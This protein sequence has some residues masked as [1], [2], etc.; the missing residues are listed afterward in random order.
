M[1]DA[2]TFFPIADSG[3]YRA[4]ARYIYG[5]VAFAD[6]LY[7]KKH[8]VQDC[9]GRALV[10]FGSSPSFFINSSSAR[11]DLNLLQ[12]PVPPSFAGGGQLKA[13]SKMQIRFG[14][15]FG[16]DGSPPPKNPVILLLHFRSKVEIYAKSVCLKVVGLA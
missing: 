16:R 4:F 15:G 7:V 2:K 11:F 3:H 8:N 14:R 13:S 6:V 5:K 1:Q 9:A 10:F 12:I